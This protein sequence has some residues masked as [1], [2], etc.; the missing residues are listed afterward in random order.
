MKFLL[1]FFSTFLFAKEIYVAAAANTAFVMPKIIKAFEKKYHQKVKLILSSSG[2]LT[3]QI[4]RKAPYD[5]FL[6]ADMKYPQKI[7]KLHYSLTP[8][9]V[10]AKGKIIVFSKKRIASLKELENKEVAIASPRVAPYGKAAIEA[11]KNANVTPKFVYAPT[12]SGVGAY[13]Q[14]GVF[15]GVVAKSMEDRLKGFFYE[16]PT[17]LYHPIKQGA[18]LLRKDGKEFFDFL[19][20]KEA[21]KIFKEAGYIE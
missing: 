14:N 21:K 1:L 5:L 12:V 10:Y 7:Y 6:S 20:S 19:F 4:L 3:A 11:F 2:K 17:K 15:A 8:P 13:V 9:K 16:I 18:V